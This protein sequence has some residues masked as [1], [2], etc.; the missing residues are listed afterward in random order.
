MRWERAQL[1]VASPHVQDFEQCGR[2]RVTQSDSPSPGHYPG[3]FTGARPI[4]SGLGT[5]LGDAA[6]STLAFIKHSAASGP[7]SPGRG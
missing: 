3:T 5:G 4:P 2:V 7:A 6:K 1:S